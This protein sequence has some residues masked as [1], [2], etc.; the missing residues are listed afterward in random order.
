MSELAYY[1]ARVIH[2]S[3]MVPAVEKRIPIR[4]L[5]T[6][7]PEHP[8]TTVLDNGT[9][10]GAVV[11]SIAQRRGLT[12]ISVVSTRMLLQHGFMARLFDVFARHEVV[13]DMIS[14]SEISVSITTNSK[15]DLTPV[16]RELSGIA[17]VE[18]EAGKAIVCVVGEG[19]RTSADTVADIFETLRRAGVV[20]RMISMGAT[21]INVSL[22]VA[23]GDVETAVRAL[24]RVFFEN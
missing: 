13:V 19:I 21:R 4:V 22:L 5:N 14:T 24:H 10:G 20:T 11:R 7:E 2:P 6:H 15:K 9:T 3:T 12:L 18:I 8:G 23:E 1:G 16:A 17:D